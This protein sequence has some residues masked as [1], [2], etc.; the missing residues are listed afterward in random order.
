MGEGRECCEL[1]NGLRLRFTVKR[2]SQK[3]FKRQGS[4]RRKTGRKK[5]KLFSEDGSQSSQEKHVDLN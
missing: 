5:E 2:K 1:N 3:G 4:Q